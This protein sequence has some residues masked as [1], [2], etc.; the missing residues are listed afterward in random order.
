M[1]SF[2]LHILICVCFVQSSV[3]QNKGGGAAA[4]A[5]AA[6]G[7]VAIG[8]VALQFHAMLERLESEA[9]NYI[10]E[11]H[12]EYEAFR[13]KVLDLDGKKISDIGAMSVVTFKLTK[14]DR[15]T[16]L[17]GERS[18][19]M[20][21]T[22][23]GW[24]TEYGIDLSLVSWSL[25]SRAEWNDMF[26]SFIDMNTPLELDT[27]TFLFNKVEALRRREFDA[28]DSLHFQLGDKY[29][30]IDSLVR[31]PALTLSFGRRGMSEATMN[32][33]GEVFYNLVLPFYPLR[34]DD[35]IVRDFSEKFKLFANERSMGLYV[36]AVKRSIQLS[37]ST[38]GEI[39]SFINTVRKEPW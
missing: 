11:N 28:Q 31:V 6:A 29:Y 39:H 21:L 38:V 12:P 30:M 20:M 32:Q 3:A 33:Y 19:L 8:A 25:F 9:F 14:L 17:E 27:S 16:G 36:K 24:V 26:G 35:Y 37:R 5:A 2:I 1:K 18:V 10:A 7:V 34:N 4:A 15:N 13:L 23:D 22:S